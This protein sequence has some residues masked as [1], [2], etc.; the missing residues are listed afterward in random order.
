MNEKVKKETSN[1]KWHI[2]K[3]T[4]PKHKFRAKTQ[5]S[6]HLLVHNF[7]SMRVGDERFWSCKK[8]LGQRKLPPHHRTARLLVL[9]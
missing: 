7:I 1:T 5:H 9:F 3:Q 6:L 4:N 2:N 8:S